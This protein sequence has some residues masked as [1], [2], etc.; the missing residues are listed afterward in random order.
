MDW[1]D[2]VAYSVH[3]LEDGVLSGLVPLGALERDG[4]ALAALAAEH[5]SALPAADLERALE[6]LLPSVP[7][8]YDGGT[9]DQAALKALTSGTIGRFCRAAERATRDRH[10]GDR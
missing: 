9:A 7:A 10:G 6:A 5:Y 4:A 8:S 1:A 2:D 3:D